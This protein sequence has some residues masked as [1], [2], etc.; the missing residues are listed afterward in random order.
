MKNKMKIFKLTIVILLLLLTFASVSHSATNRELVLKDGEKLTINKVYYKAG[1]TMPPSGSLAISAIQRIWNKLSTAAKIDAFVMCDPKEEVNA[2]ITQ[3]NKNDFLVVIQLGLLK[4]LKTEDEV[5]GVIGHEIGHGVKRHG[6]KR[7]G[8]TAG[9]VVGANLA[10]SGYSRENEVD[11]DDLGVEYSTKAGYNPW[12]LYNSINSM[13]KAGLVT[14]PSGFNSHP[15]TERRMTRLKNEAQKWEKYVTENSKTAK[16][17][18][19]EDSI[20]Q[21]DQVAHDGNLAI[22]KSDGVDVIA[23]YPI[24]QGQK[25]VLTVLHNRATT[26]YNSGKYKEAL[27]A[28]IRGVNTYKKNYLSALWAARCAQKLGDKKEMKKWVDKS[29]EINPSYVPAKQFKDMYF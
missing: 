21:A 6:E 24:D 1:V 8:N 2:F 18:T 29:L 12:G 15:P 23:S 14:P 28:F 13:S 26:L 22:N 11:A 9:V 20:K 25:N 7:Q 17:Q 5:A 19:K 16:T 3:A 10:V 27:S 4:V